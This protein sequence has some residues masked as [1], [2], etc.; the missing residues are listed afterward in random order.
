MRLLLGVDEGTTAVKAALFDLDLRPLRS[1]TRRVATAHPAPGLAE[2]DARVIRAAVVDAV[3]ELLATLGPGDEVVACGLDHQ[4]ES[5]LAW[6]PGTGEPLT[7]VVLWSDARTVTVAD[8]DGVRA[9]TGLPLDPYFSAGKLGTLVAGG[10]PAGA[11]LGT[12][13]AF[14]ADTLGGRF[15]TDASTA[16][17]TQLAAPG[18]PAWDPWLCAQ[19]GVPVGAL[20][21]IEDT[22]GALGELRHPRWP[23]ALPLHAQVVDQQAA[24][25]G[26]GCV[27]PG[28]VKATYG[29]GVFVLAHTGAAAPAA[30]GL[31]P[32][33][34]WRI[35]GAVEFAL[36]GGVFS[37]GALL[38][39]L[40]GDLGLAPDAPAL[41]ELAATVPDAGGV[42][43]LPAL[44]GLGAPWWRP[45]ARAVV[46]GLTGA[47]RPA[48]L[49]RA[50]LD[51]IAWRVA[52]VVDAV[53]AHVGLDELRAD[54]GLSRAPLLVRL[55]ADAT[56]LPVRTA[57]A[58]AT[59]AGAA[60][61]AGVGA[62]VFGSVAEAAERLPAGA[63]V[64][65]GRDGA[66]RAREHAAWRRFVETAATL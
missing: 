25:A 54:G 49:A 52:D 4:G 39:W 28:R 31:L 32:T 43:V 48:H 10:L 58:D 46:A 60:L 1:A 13:D 15:A 47:A 63:Q 7:P 18:A 61:L 36:D 45:D 12:V 51:A 6:D 57:L 24:L 11:R 22:A 62:G 2:Q 65:P 66:W 55:Q 33:V 56:G 40:S 16:S 50:A 64:A 30:D 5:V 21:A 8:P 38:E 34:A 42:R 26:T 14:L 59:V 3:A 44:G 27:V 35:G 9:R 20:P 17:R 19:F 29:T 41:A 37:A 23:V 53:A